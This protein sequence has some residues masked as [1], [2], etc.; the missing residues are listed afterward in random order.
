MP[1]MLPSHKIGEGQPRPSKVLVEPEA[2]V[3]ER[4]LSCQAGL[5]ALEGRRTLAQKTERMM[6]A[7]VDGL[8]PSVQARQPALPC[9][10]PGGGG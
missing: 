1:V 9:Q 10:G 2:E 3:V 4:H 8:N 6:H 5:E 7:G